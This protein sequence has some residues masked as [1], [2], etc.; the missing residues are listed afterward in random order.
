MSSWIFDMFELDFELG[1]RVGFRVR[2]SSW[3]SSYDVELDFASFGA[4]HVVFQPSVNIFYPCF[5]IGHSGSSSFGFCNKEHFLEAGYQPAA[6]PPTWRTRG[7][8]SSG[9]YP[10]TNPAWSDLPGTK[11]PTD[12]ALWV[13]E[14]HKLHHHG[15]VTA[16]GE[17][18]QLHYYI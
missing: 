3:I 5:P 16:Q 10:S 15:K 14:T 6:Q 12:T 8:S 13:I 11:A 2:I 7:C 1:F 17:D 18:D 9:L 4:S